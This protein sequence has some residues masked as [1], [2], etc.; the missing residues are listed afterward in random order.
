MH[1]IVSAYAGLIQLD[2]P[3]VDQKGDPLDMGCVRFDA[4]PRYRHRADGLDLSR[5]YRYHNAFEFSSGTYITHEIFRERL[6]K[7]AD[8]PAISIGA[9]RVSHTNGAIA[10]SGGPFKEL[11]DFSTTC[12][13]LGRATSA[14]LAGDFR[15][16]I[17]SV[18]GLRD[19]LFAQL[20]RNWFF[21]F[22]LV[23]NNGAVQLS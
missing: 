16:F 1:L 21:A 22:C 3:R 2:A 11:I 8:Y 6:A 13:T 18:D 14:K 19:P 9:S 17:G 4:A 15:I 12:G 5:I 20:F 23:E 10:A 7:M